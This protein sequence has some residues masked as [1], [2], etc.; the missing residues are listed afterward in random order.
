MCMRRTTCAFVFFTLVLV[1][2]G[3]APRLPPTATPTPAPS[4]T[5]TATPAPTATPRP[6]TVTV[7]GPRCPAPFRDDG[8][9]EAAVTLSVGDT[10][11]M[12]LESA[13]SVPCGWEPPEVSDET[14]IQQVAH[15]S[16]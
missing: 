8:D 7:N 3:C 15:H 1:T 2:A 13:P 5:P 4:R 16:T 11:T 14:I 6:Q 12:T 9:L 10:L